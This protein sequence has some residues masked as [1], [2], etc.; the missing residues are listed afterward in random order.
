MLK[1]WE[2]NGPP[3]YI[4]AAGYL[5]RSETRKKTAPQKGPLQFPPTPG[6]QK[7]IDAKPDTDS[8]DLNELVNMFRNMGGGFRVN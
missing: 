8:G 5:G 4:A 1:W 3:V 7:L 2:E 6:P